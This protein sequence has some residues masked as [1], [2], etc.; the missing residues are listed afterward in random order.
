MQVSVQKIISQINKHMEKTTHN[1]RT[2]CGTNKIKYFTYQM[3]K[4]GAV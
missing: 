4:E 1:Q 3:R 2:V